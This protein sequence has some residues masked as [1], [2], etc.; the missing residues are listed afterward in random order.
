MEGKTRFP[1]WVSN[2]FVFGFL[3]AVAVGYFLWQ[4]HTTREA[5]FSKM[6]AMTELVGRII[7]LNARGA[8]LSQQT[9]EEILFTFLGN[10]ARFVDYLD[11]IEPFKTEELTEFAKEARLSGICIFR[12]DKTHVEGPAQ[13]FKE[14]SHIL[15]SAP[16][17]NYDKSHHLYTFS[18]PRQEIKGWVVIGI[19]AAKIESLQQ[20]LGLPNVIETMTRLPGISY[21]RTA[22]LEKNS[23]PNSPSS[24]LIMVEHG[25]SAA[26]ESKFIID[27]QEITIGLDASPLTQSVKTLWRD[28]LLFSG[29]LV[30]MG[31][32][33]SY[34]LYRQQSLHIDA[35][36]TY[37][38][39][40]S[41]ERQ[42]AALGRAAASIAHEIRNPLN[43]LSMGLQRLKIEGNELNHEHRHFI[44]IM[45]DAVHRTNSIVTGLLHYASPQYSNP[46][47][48][49]LDL[50]IENIVPLYQARCTHQGIELETHITSRDP[51]A[52]DPGLLSQ[53]IE[54]L[55]K[56]AVEAQPQRGF[57]KIEISRTG[58]NVIMTMTNG[59]FSLPPEQVDRMTEPY[60]TTKASGTG[61]GLAIARRI[62]TEHGGQLS[63]NPLPGKTIAIRIDLPASIKNT[64]QHGKG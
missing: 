23:H 31:M 35:I 54:N 27:K 39:K 33:L 13:W 36:R 12:A 14:A 41:E 25:Q 37:E 57:L 59:G 40:M 19:E 51:V 60:F 55:L 42:D 16:Y 58:D 15:D 26:V 24:T 17:L 53:V 38:R 21:I 22:L 34:L 64:I 44:E 45:L 29:A 32:L 61:L 49:R 10:T 48:V 4:I 7:E 2:L 46:Q 8:V 52:G 11:T 62:I 47:Q 9:T 6:Q 43:S 20:Q 63:V 5:F 28:F 18:W 56:N 3:C 1:L 50:L 30:C